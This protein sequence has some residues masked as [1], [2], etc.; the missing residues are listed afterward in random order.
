[1]T[2][3]LAVNPGGSLSPDQVVGRD[4]LINQLWETLRVQSVLLS[5][6]RRMG[7]TSVIRK[8]AA[9]AEAQ[10]FVGVI[11]S[12]E[13]CS[14]AGEFVEQLA[15]GLRDALPRSHRAA[16]TLRS[17]ISTWGVEVDSGP[18][19]IQPRLREDWKPQ[20]QRLFEAVT[21]HQDRPV[22]LFI[23]ELSMMLD[24]V[25]VRDG[26][27]VARDVLDSLRAARQRHPSLRM[28][29]SGSIGLHHVL[30][31]LAHPGSAWAP[32][33]DMDRVELTPL[34]PAEA[35]SLAY[36]LL[37][38]A[39]IPC[40][41]PGAVAT[42]IAAEVDGVPYYVHL[43][44]KWLRA[45]GPGHLVGTEDVRRAVQAGIEG[46]PDSWNL[47]YLGERIIARYAGSAT[48]AEQVLDIVATAGP[49]SAAL[50]TAE[51]GRRLGSVTA[52]VDETQ[53]RHAVELL[54]LDH[55]LRR[56][57]SFQLSIARRYWIMSRELV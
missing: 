22:V 5:A 28:V 16:A 1:M 4:L 35:T 9:D 47:S 3:P 48:L 2:E 24:K 38:G 34:V 37:A 21:D 54:R 31:D 30:G 20:L 11:R 8:M 39:R 12:V 43:T 23:D 26:A 45:L 46:L 51:I 18:I 56:D 6:E 15:A 13:D 36:R 52:G 7:K 55:Y 40:Q 17:L 19:R 57:N 32:V 42:A 25:R 53:L 10:G 14:S 44:V 50:T 27:F 29:V 33:N 49:G 41:D